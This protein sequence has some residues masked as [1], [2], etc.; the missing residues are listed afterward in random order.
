MSGACPSQEVLDAAAAKRLED[1]YHLISEHTRV[2]V[3]APVPVNVLLIVLD[4][5]K[6]T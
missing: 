3:A 5:F 6:V 4:M 1:T 2:A